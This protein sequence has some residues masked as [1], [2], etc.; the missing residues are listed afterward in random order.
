MSAPD[1]S[2]YQRPVELLQNLIRFDTT[3]PPGNEG[4]CIAYIASLLR[5][6]G[7]EPEIVSKEPDR[8]NLICRMKGRGEA[9]ALMLYG[10][11]DVVTAAGREWSHD[12]F[13]GDL[14]DGYV[15]GRG[16]VDMKGGVAMFLSAFMR[17]QVEGIKPAGDIV[18]VALA[19]EESFGVYGAEYLVENH[20]DALSDVKYALGEFGGF[21]MSLAGKRFYPIQVAEKQ[22]CT[23][24]LMIRG[25]G[26]HGASIVPGNAMEELGK[27]LDR[28]STKR[29]PVHI[30]P[31][32]REM[33][34]RISE[35]LKFPLRQAVRL[36]LIPSLTDKVLDL[37]G[38]DGLLF[39]PLLHNSVNPTIAR[40][41][42]KSNVVPSE[43]SL[44]LDG[45]L[46][47]GFTPD[48]MIAEVGELLEGLDVEITVRL[49]EEGPPE[50]DMGLFPFLSEMLTAFDPEG[51]PIP[52]LLMAVT[53]ARHLAKIG[54]QSYGF[55]PMLLEQ[56][57]SIFSSVHGVDER[58][59]IAAVEFG[60]KVV[61]QT[62]QQYQG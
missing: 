33:F 3:N 13:S 4:E 52:Y 54:I 2:I 12:P 40:G 62:L 24:Q 45:R 1:I 16:A 41:G 23:L 6:V 29:L 26:G 51:I 5:G 43:V 61:F 8:P 56:D 21:S 44:T 11:V 46:L 15:W 34:T 37:L 19:D 20:Q 39:A 22:V 47:P 28:V 30:T 31:P 53:D 10:H 18:F 32:V 27:V 42:E 38:A 17:M 49:F 57:I 60:A 14:A 58:V 55:T 59:P 35:S 50:A 48:D 36:L 25:E 7:L 9:P